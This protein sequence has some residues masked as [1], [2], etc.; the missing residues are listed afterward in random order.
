MLS[1]DMTT[2][3]QC[4]C[5]TVALVPGRQS[6]VV[7]M[8]CTRC[9]SEALISGWYPVC[10]LGL[11]VV[12]ESHFAPLEQRTQKKRQLSI[13][14]EVSEVVGSAGRPHSVS[15]LPV[16]RSS[17]TTL[18]PEPQARLSPSV[19]ADRPHLLAVIL[20]RPPA[21]CSVLCRSW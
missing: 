1:Y 19:R 20:S 16:L 18:V 15:T 9:S 3:W 2:R 12:G 8:M 13:P 11:K 7:S 17:K 4:C 5:I 10:C 6:L 21:F 14:K